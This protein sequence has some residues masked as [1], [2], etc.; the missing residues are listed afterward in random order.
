MQVLETAGQVGRMSVSTTPDITF[1][2]MA[3]HCEALLTAKRKKMSLFM[4]SQQGQEILPALLTQ[5]SDP[6]DYPP[7]L[8]TNELYAVCNLKASDFNPKKK[9]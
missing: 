5:E 2:E 4:N 9:G 6:E 8:Q 1:K 7:S 3:G